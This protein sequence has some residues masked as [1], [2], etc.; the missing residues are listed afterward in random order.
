MKCASAAHAA[1]LPNPPSTSSPARAIV[2]KDTM[3]GYHR[4]TECSSAAHESRCCTNLRSRRQS[5]ERAPEPR[6]RSSG[7]GRG[8]SAPHFF[9]E[10]GGGGAGAV[11]GEV[12]AVGA[13]EAR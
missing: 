12:D 9:E 5:T 6:R 1:M 3:H 4:R 11:D 2:S 7:R 8:L 10:P 13:D